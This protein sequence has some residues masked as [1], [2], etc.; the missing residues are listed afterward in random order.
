VKV[1]MPAV[2]W[3]FLLLCNIAFGRASEIEQ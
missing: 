1:E 3:A 2:T